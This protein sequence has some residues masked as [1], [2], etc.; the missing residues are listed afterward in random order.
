MDALAAAAGVGQ[1]NHLPV[2]AEQVGS[3]GRSDERTA[4]VTKVPAVEHRD[5]SSP[6]LS[7]FFDIP[8]SAVPALDP[9]RGRCER[10]TAETQ[11]NP[12]AAEILRFVHRG[13]R[14]EALT[15]LLVGEDKSEASWPFRCRLAVVVDQAFGFVWYRML[16]GHVRLSPQQHYDWP[17][18]WWPAREI[19]KF[20]GGPPAA[21]TCLQP[22]TP[23]GSGPIWAP[24]G[25]RDSALVRHPFG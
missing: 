15:S 25:R 23:P 22:F 4:P 1:A 18:V 2:V 19:A 11:I 24:C 16:V 7:E 13:T 5:L 10:S 14:R 8:R 9:S 3:P 12:Q 17:T 6:I 20:D 21:L